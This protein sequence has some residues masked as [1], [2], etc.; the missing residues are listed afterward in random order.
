MNTKYHTPKKHKVIT[1]FSANATSKTQNANGTK[2]TE[3]IFEIPPM[4]L[5]QNAKISL[6]YLASTGSSSNTVYTVR[7]KEIDKHHAFDNQSGWGVLYSQQGLNMIQLNMGNIHHYVAELNLN[8]LTISVSDS[9]L[10]N[11]RDSGISTGIDFVMQ[12]RLFDDDYE[13][14]D[15]YYM[16]VY[17]PV[18]TPPN[19]MGMNR[20][21]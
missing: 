1:L 9:I 10:A 15:D 6:I 3:F 2:Y 21:Y 4:E 12:F 19:E 18:I 7:C 16:G 20:F 11:G 8:R 13:S 14:V 17:K 5:S